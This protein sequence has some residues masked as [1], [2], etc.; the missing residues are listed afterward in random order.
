MWSRA[1]DGYEVRWSQSMFKNN[2][3]H[4]Q[5]AQVRAQAVLAHYRRLLLVISF[6]F[7]N[8]QNTLHN[9]AILCCTLERHIIN[10]Q[11][12][13][14]R[15]QRPVA[16]PP[17]LI[18]LMP[19]ADNGTIL[20]QFHP[21]PSSQP[22]SLTFWHQSFRFNSNKSPTWCNSFSVYYPDVCLQLNMLLFS[23]SGRQARPR[24]QHDY[25]H[26]TKVK[27]EAVIELLMMD[28]KRPE[29][30]WAVNKHR[31]INWKIVASG[32]WFI[33]IKCKTPVPKC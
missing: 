24:T 17:G 9:R 31:I 2:F 32:W 4:S 3:W 21:L 28:G 16:K 1:R 18:P 33:W 20:G 27:P 29:T 22:T 23:W 8:P 15:T 7:K 6:G 11:T 30:C 25:H 12:P 26:D 14:S 13:T 5:K 19:Q 10:S